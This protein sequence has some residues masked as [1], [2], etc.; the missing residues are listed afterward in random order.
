M[1][2]THYYTSITNNY[3][4]KA[5]ILAR[6]IRQHDAEAIIH[7]VLCDIPPEDFAL[8]KEPFDHLHLV[9]DLD[10]PNVLSWLFQHSLVEM[11]TGA[12]GPA[13][14]KILTEYDAD[15]VYYF[16]PDI[17]VL[18][19][20]GRLKAEL[21]QASVVL[22][23]HQVVPEEK[24]EDVRI[25]EITSLK[26]GVY[27]LGFVGVRRSDCGLAFARWWRDR[28][29][30]Y[31]WADIPNGLFTD[32]RW[33]DLAPAL[34]NDVRVLRDKHYN[35]ATWNLTHRHVTL[36]D[37]KLVIDGQP[38]VFFHFSGFDSGGQLMMLKKYAPT[39][40]PL[41]ELHDWYVRE[42][43][44]AG[45]RELGNVKSVYER[46]FNGEPI[47]PLHRRIYRE[48]PDLIKRF[49]DPFAVDADYSFRD[50]MKQ[51][52]PHQ[53]EPAPTHETAAPLPN[54]H[55]DLTATITWK[56][57]KAITSPIERA[58]NLWPG[59][60]PAIKRGLGRWRR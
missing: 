20:L 22:T 7:L 27:N 35:V 9:R 26:Y 10:I 34:F 3:L 16:D 1:G 14:W 40:S 55:A 39:N 48:R 25:N 21:A 59:L 54:T 18:H 33:C 23:P 52:Y 49:P 38:I 2:K 8:D 56:V 13:L 36:S 12:K 19:D 46:Y 4:P 51:E 32:Q 11:C 44:A 60:T 37:G 41:F 24:D 43:D 58:V 53:P 15:Q 29:L 45:Q 50:W 5:R 47:A 30:A 42:M 57:G 6:S 31:C 28:L 17:V